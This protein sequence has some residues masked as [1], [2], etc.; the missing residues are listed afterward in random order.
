MVNLSQL[1][2]PERGGEART[3]GSDFRFGV[4]AE[5]T[6]FRY[7]SLKRKFYFLST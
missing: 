4:E 5:K 1:V 6:H 2:D 7:R 3:A